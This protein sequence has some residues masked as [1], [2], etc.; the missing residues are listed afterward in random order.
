MAEQSGFFPDVNGDREYT[1]DFLAQWVA[2]FLSN[3]TY[4]GE[5]AVQAGG[6][7]MSVILPAGKAW[8]NG[9]YY[10]NDGNLTFPIANADGILNRRDTV[11]LRWDVNERS[12]KALVL[13]GTPAG[14]AAAPAMVR[15]AEQYDLKLA[16]ISIPAGTTAITQSLITDTRL[17]TDV[18]GIVHAVVD[19][20]DTTAFYQQIQNDLAQFRNTSETGFTAWVDGLKTILDKTAAGNL[21][22]EIDAL[23]SGKSDKSKTVTTTLSASGW[24]GSSAPYSQTVAV[25]GITATS[26]NDWLPTVDA[27]QEQ[28]EAWDAANIKDGGQSAGSATLKAWGDKPTVDI[29]VQVVIGG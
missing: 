10:R 9:Y 8:I 29:P 11:V 24:T 4:N 21:Q 28:I 25:S 5:L 1:S 19:H 14:T 2:S 26:V 20:I 23:Q 12:I 27:T 6:S 7:T 15:T 13:K 17:N 3:G 18:C 22:N 16:E